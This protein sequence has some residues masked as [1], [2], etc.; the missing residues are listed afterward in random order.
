[1]RLQDVAGDLGMRHQ[2]GDARRRFPAPCR[3]A[4]G[5][6]RTRSRRSQ[7]SPTKPARPAAKATRMPSTTSTSMP[8]DDPDP[9]VDGLHQSDLFQHLGLG[10]RLF[11]D[12][13]VQRHRHR[14]FKPEHQGAAV[15]PELQQQAQRE[16]RKGDRH[17]Q[18]RR[19][20]RHADVDGTVARTPGPG[21]VEGAVEMRPTRPRSSATISTS[22]SR[23]E[24]NSKSHRVRPRSAL[25]SMSMRI[26]VP[27]RAT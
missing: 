4:R 2:A 9:D 18:L 19:P 25:T 21:A 3:T 12:G 5:R 16:H 1:M 23:T 10:P 24:M 20:D 6:S 13:E 15:A 14:V 27:S 7:T 22:I 8:A 11:R 26:C 17:D